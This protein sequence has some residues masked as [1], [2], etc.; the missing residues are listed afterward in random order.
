M[1]HDKHPPSTMLMANAGTTA[2]GDPSFI[3]EKC[4]GT[5]MKCLNGSAAAQNTPP[6]A[7]SV[8]IIIDIHLNVLISGLFKFPNRILPY[9]E[10]PKKSAMKKVPNKE[11][12]YIIPK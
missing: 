12:W 5:D 9:F 3:L 7:S 8:H 6:A 2:S 4:G 1:A 10:I 11:I